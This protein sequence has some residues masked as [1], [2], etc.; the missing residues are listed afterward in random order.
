MAYLERWNQLRKERKMKP[1][2]VIIRA[3]VVKSIRVLADSQEEAIESAHDLFT[4]DCEGDEL[5]YE[6][7]TVEVLQPETLTRD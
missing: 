7:E 4:V 3:I 1:Y 6:Q 2:E 5:R